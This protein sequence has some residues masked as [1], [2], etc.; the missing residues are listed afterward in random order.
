MWAH[1]G[2]PISADIMRN[3]LPFTF[4]GPRSGAGLGCSLGLRCFGAGA[5]LLA[6]GKAVVKVRTAASEASGSVQMLERGCSKV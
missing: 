1:M 6:E 2:P 4:V 5:G 3:A